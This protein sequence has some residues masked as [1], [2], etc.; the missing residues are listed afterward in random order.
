MLRRL[1]L[2]G[3]VSMAGLGGLLVAAAPAAHAQ[4]EVCVNAQV[5]VAGTQLVNQS[6]CE[7]IPGAPALP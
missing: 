4:G 3:S 1:V 2:A 5:N 7:T 6:P